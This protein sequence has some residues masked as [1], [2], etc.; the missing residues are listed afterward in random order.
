M[1]PVMNRQ[2][3]QERCRQGWE[4]RRR[5]RTWQEVAD[6]LGFKSRQNALKAVNK[7]LEKNPPDDLETM[8]RATGDTLIATTHKLA[9][10]LDDAIDA[11]KHRDAAELGK[12]VLDGL[13]KYAKLTGQHVVVPQVVDVQVTQTVVEM[14]TDTRAKLQAAIDAEV[15]PLPEEIEA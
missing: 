1:P 11:G 2:A 4:L 3:S 6:E 13:D 5:G 9:D 15:V 14:I 8:R 10:A 12:V 7:W